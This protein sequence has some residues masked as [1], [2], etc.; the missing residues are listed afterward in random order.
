MRVSSTAVLDNYGRPSKASE[1]GRHGHTFPHAVF[2]NLIIILK[3]KAKS[4]SRLVVVWCIHKG[5]QLHL[6]SNCLSS[7]SPREK[8][9]GSSH[10]SL[11]QHS[12]RVDLASQRLV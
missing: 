8:I 2:I 11:C 7:A 5:T 9:L 3:K 10:A 12:G 6:A 1:N 4:H